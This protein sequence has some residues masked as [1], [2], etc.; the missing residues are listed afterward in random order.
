MSRARVFYALWIAG[1]IA[2]FC[3]HFPHLLA[4]FPNNSPWLDYS[5]Y[6]DEGWY[7]SAAARYFLNGHWY[8]HGDFNAAVALPVWPILLG[9]VFRFTGVSLA[10]ARATMLVIFG[11][12]L[13]L[14]YRILRSQA[15]RWVAFT[16]ITLLVTSPFLYAFSRL[17]I[18]EPLVVCL[19][20]L[21]WMLAL[22]LNGAQNTRSERARVGKLIG[23]GLLLCLML[24]TKTTGL[25]LAPSTLFLVAWA[26]GFR[27]RAS[28]RAL[29]ITAAAAV[30]PWSAWY[31]FLVRPH[32]RF[33]FA[34]FYE[35]NHWQQP[36]GFIGHLAA[37]WWALHG[38]LWISPVLCIATG[39]LLAA[40]LLPRRS[41][42]TAKRRGSGGF[43]SNPLAA[44]SLLAA[45]GYTFFIGMQN[46]PQPR[47]YQATIYPMA[48][49]LA[50]GAGELVRHIHAL[51]MRAVGVAALA[52]IACVSVFG[53]TKI[54]TYVVHPE[55]TWLDA[56]NGVVA[57]I[58]QHPAPNRVLLSISGDELELITHLPSL[59]DDYGTWDLPY[60][61]HTYQPSWYATWNELDPGTLEDLSTQYSLERVAS[62]QAFDDPD[63]DELILY[64][65]LPLPPRQQK[66]FASEERVDNAGK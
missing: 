32:Y 27:W 9:L 42:L 33:D 5:K 40:T 4:D 23:I 11:L 18:L 2:L 63:R 34:Y 56:A 46:N 13:L 39:V 64:R 12:N 14:S 29:A 41:D 25:F 48:F 65:M 62:F 47:Y 8:L 1:I 44:A 38:L 54:A 52:A 58:D 10:A 16:A 57:Y 20:L 17:A 59:C 19:M 15:P 45:A 60:R 66:Y 61:I 30:V 43:W 26:C 51:P 53:T 22:R 21:S 55:Y 36:V 7:G 24:M 37:Y 31:F 28:V 50:L 49:L 35:V 6:T 3:L